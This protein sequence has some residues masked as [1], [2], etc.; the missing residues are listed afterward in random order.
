MVRIST[1]LIMQIHRIWVGLFEA[2]SVTPALLLRALS[3]EKRYT[4]QSRP[5]NKSGVKGASVRIIRPGVAS[6]QGM[7][8]GGSGL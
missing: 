6:S 1:A 8:Q 4:A 7:G 2:A 3:A 5:P